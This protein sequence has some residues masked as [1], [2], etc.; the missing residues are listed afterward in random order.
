MNNTETPTTKLTPREV[1]E[2][3]ATLPNV[4]QVRYLNNRI[5]VQYPK[6]RGGRV[7]FTLLEARRH[8]ARQR[9]EYGNR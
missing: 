8:L 4:E 9:E 6:L 3:L 5:M 2:A 1:A 7:Y